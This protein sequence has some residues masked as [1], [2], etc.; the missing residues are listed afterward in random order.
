MDRST[1]L[2]LY[3]H[4]TEP[5]NVEAGVPQGSPLSSILFMLYN[6]EL[7][8]ICRPP[9][10]GLSSDLK[11]LQNPRDSAWEMPSLGP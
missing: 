4:K 5:F 2:V 6:S 9:Y 7:F 1:S 3:D 10:E 11:H 8:D